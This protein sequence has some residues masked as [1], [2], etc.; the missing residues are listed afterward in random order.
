MEIEE[1]VNFHFQFTFVY[2]EAQVNER[3]KTWDMLKSLV[4]VNPLPWLCLGDFNEV[5]HAHEHVGSGK[6]RASQIAG[7]RDAMDVCALD[8]LGYQGRPWTFE[9]TT[10]GGTYCR[11]RLD[12]AMVNSD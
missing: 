4:L 9:K 1:L 6:R 3:Y 8:E 5:L 2:G 12:R 11:V 10:A 7:F